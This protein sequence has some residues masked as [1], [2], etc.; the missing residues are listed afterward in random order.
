MFCF[1]AFDKIHGFLK[2]P[3][4]IDHVIDYFRH[5]ASVFRI[6]LLVKIIQG[7]PCDMIDVQGAAFTDKKFLP[8]YNNLRTSL[9]ITLHFLKKDPIS[10]ESEF[11]TL[12]NQISNNFEKSK[13]LVFLFLDKKGFNHKSLLDS[14]LGPNNC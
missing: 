3:E 6:V 12:L 5:D 8:K 11:K 7:I 2:S 14:M 9:I 4:W 1:I 13:W 10:F